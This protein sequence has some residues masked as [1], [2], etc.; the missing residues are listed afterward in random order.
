L[1]GD[2]LLAWS[3]GGSPVQFNSAGVLQAA[4]TGGTIIAVKDAGVLNGLAILPNGEFLAA[5]AI[6]GP[7]GKTNDDAIVERFE[8]T[9]VLDTTYEP[10]PRR[11]FV[12]I[13]SPAFTVTQ[14]PWRKNVHGVT[15]RH[16]SS[17]TNFFHGY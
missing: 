17:H 1:T 4:V 2:A 11:S 15:S 10:D 3:G 7:D 6:E 16:M 14:F 8:L 13:T 12:P 9:G 5:G